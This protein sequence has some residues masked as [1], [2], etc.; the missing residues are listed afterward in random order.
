MH[1]VSLIKPYRCCSVGLKS[2]QVLINMLGNINRSS[3]GHFQ[4]QDIKK[5]G[6]P[7]QPHCSAHLF[8]HFKI[9]P[10]IHLHTYSAS[11]AK[12]I[13]ASEAGKE[14]T[15]SRRC[16]H[17]IATQVAFLILTTKTRV[18]YINKLKDP[19]YTVCVGIKKSNSILFL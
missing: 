16:H 1:P 14:R 15:K 18:K 19:L 7:S 17:V 10:S 6:G 13:N 9:H 11:T 4:E 2:A 5:Q 3:L 8:S 12:E